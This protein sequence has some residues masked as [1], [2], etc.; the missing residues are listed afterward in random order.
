M[1]IIRRVAWTTFTGIVLAVLAGCEGTMPTLGGAS[2][3]AVTGG[4]AGAGSQGASKQLEHCDQPLGTASLV[5]D[6]SAEWWR[7]YQANYSQLGSTIPVIRT[8]VQ[9][10]NC[11]VIV[12]RGSAMRNIMRERE[13]MQ[14]GELRSGSQYGKGQLVAADY[15]IS[16]SIQFSQKGTG[17]AK[18]LLGGVLGPVGG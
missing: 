11:F 14:S 17:G 12:E 7:Y 3:M 2:G 4:A 15:T 18:G 9:Q 10:S 8:L 5:E 16:P 6:Q 13:L 1:Q